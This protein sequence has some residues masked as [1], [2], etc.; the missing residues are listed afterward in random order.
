M[1]PA[2]SPVTAMEASRRPVLREEQADI[3]IVGIV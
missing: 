3:T 2:R 1:E